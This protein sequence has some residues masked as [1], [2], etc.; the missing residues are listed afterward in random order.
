VNNREVARY[1][2]SSEV[3]ERA[4]HEIY[5]TAFKIALEAKPLALMSSYN[6]INGVY[7]RENKYLLTDILR[8]ELKYRGLVVSDWMGVKNGY[9]ALKAGTTLR[10]PACD[11]AYD[12]LKSAYDKGLISEADVDAAV[13]QILETLRKIESLY[14]K[15]K[16][17]CS[18]EQR[19]S[20]SLKIAEESIV[21]LKNESVL[22]LDGK[23]SVC[24]ISDLN[25]RPYIGGGGAAEV[26]PAYTQ[27][28]LSAY[29]GDNLQIP[30]S[31]SHRVRLDGLDPSHNDREGALLASENDVAIVLVGNSSTVEI[32]GKDRETLRLSSKEE[33]LIKSVAATGVKTV[34]VI[35]A[36]SAIDVSPWIDDVDA[37]LFAGYLGD[38]ANQAI[39]N[40]L[41]G[42]ACPSG[43]LSE[44]FPLDLEHTYCKDDTGNG[45]VEVY[46][47]GVLVGYRYYDTKKVPVRYPFGFGLSYASFVYSNLQMQKLDNAKFEISFTITNTS[48][49]DGMETCQVYVKD[50][51]STV[52]KP[53][54]ELKAFEKIAIK[55]GESQTVT[56][57]LDESAFSHYDVVD[58]CDYVENGVFTVMIGA[59][60]RDI[61]L[62]G[63]VTVTLPDETQH[64]VM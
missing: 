10:M 25:N 32:E 38:N 63:N 59:S 56:L 7:A 16:V 39:A 8:G 40:I 44:T 11:S 20:R 34:V 52:I 35:E 53:E 37:V 55:A 30:I 33:R 18:R 62:Q 4:L 26:L 27:R 22:P 41:S 23:K 58:K 47:D 51:V 48:T 61:R 43:K 17:T 24:V 9:K 42:K 60:S 36:G 50:V 45:N 1:C 5:L 14:D 13:S 12:E 28:P 54:K 31:I 49:T 3:S 29:L 21:L 19:R 57:C 64:S 6:P 15:R 2:Q 46:D